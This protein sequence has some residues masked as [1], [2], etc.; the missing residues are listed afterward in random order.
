MIAAW[1][2]YGAVV[3]ALLAAGAAALDRALRAA[4]RSTRFVW[5]AAIAASLLFP[6]LGAWRATRPVPLVAATEAATDAVE[7]ERALALLRLL[8]AA[9]EQAQGAVT[10]QAAWETLDRPLLAAWGAGSL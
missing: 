5:G 1:M 4:G 8:A 2:L 10:P 9:R 6:A 7:R 3:A